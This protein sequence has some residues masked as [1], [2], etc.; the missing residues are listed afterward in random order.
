[1]WP[2]WPS[3]NVDVADWVASCSWLGGLRR[4]SVERRQICERG[5][6]RHCQISESCVAFSR[7]GATDPGAAAQPS[8]IPWQLD[9]LGR[10]CEKGASTSLC[11]RCKQRLLKGV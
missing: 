7:H 5:P 9:S 11:H 6:A 2:M 8:F 3:A 4:C 1:M 10:I